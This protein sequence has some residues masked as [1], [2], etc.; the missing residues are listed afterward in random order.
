[1]STGKL[2]L[3]LSALRLKSFETTPDPKAGRGTVVG[4]DQ[5]CSDCTFCSGCSGCT[6]VT[7]QAGASACSWNTCGENTNCAGASHTDSGAYT[8]YCDPDTWYCTEYTPC[9]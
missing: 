4:M 9:G 7:C 5:V 6:A 8:Q 3:S 1:M 2:R